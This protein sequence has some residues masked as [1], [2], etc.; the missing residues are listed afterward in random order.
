MAFHVSAEPVRL[1][2]LTGFLGAGKTTLLN[3]LLADPA[4]T[5]TG[6]I[7]N[8]FGAVGVDH[9]LVES[10]SDGLIELSG[11]C[12]CCSV[13]GDLADTLADLV[14]RMQTGRIAPL[15]RVVVET[16]GL[17]DPTP[18]LALLIGHPA[19]ARA[20]ALDGVVTVVDALAGPANLAEHV[21]ARRQAAVADRIVLTKTDLAD[22]GAADRLRGALRDLNPGAPMLDAAKGEAAADTLFGCGPFDPNA[23][24]TDVRAWLR[25]EGGQHDH[26]HHHHRHHA[27]DIGSLVIERREPIGE[28]DLRGFMEALAGAAGPG[29]LRVKGIAH[30][31]EA[32]ERP[33]V[34]HGVRGFFHPPARLGAW[35]DGME[36]AT[37]LVVIGEGLDERRVR[38]LFAAFIGEPRID[39]PDRQALIDNPLAVPGFRS[40]TG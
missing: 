36:P 35:P 33:L 15:K 5:D 16:T 27:P 24:S 18:I 23:K 28:R 37:R 20:Y 40:L 17:A 8:E 26:P 38:D 39:A 19:L 14:D 25:E 13:R 31:R 30:V 3:R 4:V 34:L 21:E 7:V 22:A 10:A 1:T 11:G 9:L 2:L 6:V 32:V 29:L 12:L